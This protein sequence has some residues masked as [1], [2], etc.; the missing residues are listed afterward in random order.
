MQLLLTRLDET[1]QS[2]SDVIEQNQRLTNENHALK[3]D[4]SRV[5]SKC[6]RL[7]DAVQE[8]Q[9]VTT[10]IRDVRAVPS[11]AHTPQRRNQFK[12][13]ACTGDVIALTCLNRGGNIMTTTAHYGQYAST[14]ADCC[15]SNPA[16]DCTELVEDNR[17]SDWL[18]IKALCDNQTSCQFQNLGSLI[19]TCEV[20]YQSDYMEVFYD[21]VGGEA[22]PVGFTAYADTGSDSYYDIGDKL[23]FDQ[24]ISN[25]GGHYNAGTSEFTCP[26]DGVYLVSL[27][28][29][30]YESDA[31][32]ADIF[33]GGYY[34]AEVYIDDVSGTYN[35][36]STTIVADCDGGDV[37]WIR[38]GISGS[39]NAYDRRCLFTVYMLHQY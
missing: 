35:R 36:G 33:L 39:I 26:H 31:M 17:P 25:L 4:I 20:G 10:K 16:A 22:T 7:A 23:L 8:L 5:D 3:E 14:C 37:I 1:A 29:S 12:A 24:V 2:L 30:A 38:A 21:C 9:D 34:Q 27:H 13:F 15:A 18:A 6:D 32:I 19:N 28:L 11:A